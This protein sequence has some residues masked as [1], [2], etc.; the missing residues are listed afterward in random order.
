MQLRSSG[1]AWGCVG[2][3]QVDKRNGMLLR[4]CWSRFCELQALDGRICRWRHSFARDSVQR[5]AWFTAALSQGR[6]SRKRGV[7][8][9][10]R[11]A[12]QATQV[13]RQ[14]DA[15]GPLSPS[16]VADGRHPPGQGGSSS[17]SIKSR[18][19]GGAAGLWREP[20]P[21]PKLPEASAYSPQSPLPPPPPSAAARRT[22]SP[23]QP[24]S[25]SAHP[26]PRRLPETDNFVQLL[27]M[28]TGFPVPVAYSGSG[29]A[30][31]PRRALRTPVLESASQPVGGP[32]VFGVPGRAPG[33]GFQ[34]V[35]AVV[36]TRAPRPSRPVTMQTAGRPSRIEQVAPP[37]I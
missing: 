34:P 25:P 2:P 7:Q 17:D 27:D 35:H 1:L 14:S 12:I 24:R 21:P 36:S 32:G 20:S 28:S 33:P 11:S 3:V 22:P 15:S 23:K 37:A 18:P 19:G 30:R 26:L 4:R 29:R 6:A 5:P 10:S 31:D 8:T 9:T 16:L 13:P